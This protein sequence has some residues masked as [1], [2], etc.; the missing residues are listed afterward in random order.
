M[1]VDESIAV[2]AAHNADP[3]DCNL[4]KLNGTKA[5]N[6]DEKLVDAEDLTRDLPMNEE[7]DD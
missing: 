1:E 2:K 5:P 6:E 7:D 3:L 4:Q